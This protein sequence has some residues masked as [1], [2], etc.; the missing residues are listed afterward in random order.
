[1]NPRELLPGFTTKRDARVKPS[2]LHRW[3]QGRL[4]YGTRKERAPGAV[5]VRSAET[6]ELLRVEHPPS[7]PPSTKAYLRADKE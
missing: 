3:G 6:G 1:M 5:T 2:A 7:I 4:G